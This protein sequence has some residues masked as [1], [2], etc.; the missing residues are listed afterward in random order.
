MNQM[1]IRA[2]FVADFGDPVVTNDDLFTNN[3]MYSCDLFFSDEGTVI[4]SFVE[5]TLWA[6]DPGTLEVV[7]VSNGKW[8]IIGFGEPTDTVPVRVGRSKDWEIPNL[9]DGGFVA[10]VF[11]F[12]SYEEAQ[13][14]IQRAVGV[15]KEYFDTGAD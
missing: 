2:A 5:D 8:L 7:Q 12:S 9:P 1:Q 15:F 6:G 13:K 4:V 3:E 11:D 10:V 14:T